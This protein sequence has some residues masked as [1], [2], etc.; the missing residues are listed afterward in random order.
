ML[1]T[2]PSRENLSVVQGAQVNLEQNSQKPRTVPPSEENQTKKKTTPISSEK[3]EEQ[4]SQNKKP[5]KPLKS[6]MYFPLEQ[7]FNI[8][9]R[10]KDNNIFRTVI[11]DLGIKGDKDD[12]ERLVKILGIAADVISEVRH[13]F[14]TY[15]RIRYNRYFRNTPDDEKP[16]IEKFDNYLYCWALK[17]WPRALDIIR[18]RVQY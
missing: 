12:I 10:D 15:L 11:A 3:T 18:E 14:H 16:S 7:I 17:I 5:E 1:C 4:V 9:Y 13:Q 6:L 2:K 8:W